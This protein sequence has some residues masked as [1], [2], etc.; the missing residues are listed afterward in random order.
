MDGKHPRTTTGM[1]TESPNLTT[2]MRTTLAVGL[3][4]H[5]WRRRFSRRLNDPSVLRLNASIRSML[6]DAFV[7]DTTT[8]CHRWLHN[9]ERK[10][11]NEHPSSHG[12]RDTN[13][14]RNYKIAPG[15]VAR[16]CD[17]GGVDL[18]GDTPRSTGNLVAKSFTRDD[19]I[20]LAW[21][22]KALVHMA[23]AAMPCGGKSGNLTWACRLQLARPPARRGSFI[24]I[25]TIHLGLRG[26]DAGQLAFNPLIDDSVGWPCLRFSNSK[27]GTE[28]LIPLSAKAADTIRA[29]QA[30]VRERCPGG[31]PWLFPGIEKNTD[32]HLPYAHGSLSGQLGSWQRLIDV[33]DETGQPV[34]VQAHQFRH[35]VGTRLINAGVPQHVV[36]SATPS[37]SS[38]ASASTPPASTSTPASQAP[39]ESP[40]DVKGSLKSKVMLRGTT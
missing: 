26:D 7:G 23:S 13:L 22:S 2:L 18:S 34:R 19:D 39:S 29:Q 11:L 33:H 25:H 4:P 27:I 31:S 12:H 32:G 21:R 16:H 1:Q 38:A 30:H 40:M 3:K 17:H 8:P 10:V 35:T 6:Q 24:G 15:G 20:G 9:G 36:Q 5:R 37:R 28:Q 14:S